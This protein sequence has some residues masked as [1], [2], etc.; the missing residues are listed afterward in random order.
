M[1]LWGY[2]LGRVNF[3]QVRRQLAPRCRPLM[4]SVMAE[5]TFTLIGNCSGEQACVFLVSPRFE[6]F[7]VRVS[8]VHFC[9][10]N[11]A[12]RVLQL[13]SR[14]FIRICHLSKWETRID[15]ITGGYSL[16]I[17]RWGRGAE[18]HR[19]SSIYVFYITWTKVAIAQGIFC[20]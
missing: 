17:P 13:L 14:I 7:V 19:S 2:T 8:A 10:P 18:K 16:H 9:G 12:C 5:S 1:D 20:V 15:I 6:W 3:I 11:I 4:V